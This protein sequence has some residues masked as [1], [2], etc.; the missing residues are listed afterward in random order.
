MSATLLDLAPADAAAT[1]QRWVE[2]HG[3]PA[4]RAAQLQRRLWQAP[5]G[6]W[7]DATELPLALRAQLDAELP[8]PR[9]IPETMQIITV[10]KS[11]NCWM[12]RTKM[13]NI[14]TITATG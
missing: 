13:S 12:G 7:Q 2:D 6:S 4:Y 10:S 11:S 3:L 9:L 8:L 1:L 14:R 5:V